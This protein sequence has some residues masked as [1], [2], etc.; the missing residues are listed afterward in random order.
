MNNVRTLLIEDHRAA[1]DL[2]RDILTEGFS[3]GTYYD[4]TAVPTITEAKVV[5]R[6]RPIDLVLLD[7]HLPNGAGISLIH[8]IKEIVPLAALIIITG[9]DEEEIERKAFTMHVDDFILKAREGADEILRICR[10]AVAR[11]RARIDL[12]AST[13]DKGLERAEEQLRRW[14]NDPHIPPKI[15]LV[16]S[17]GKG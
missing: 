13:P 1:V 7:L 10:K 16:S 6:E 8:Q 3:T 11:S 9:L 14:E 2:Y 4:V 17:D 12:A 5:L 15:D